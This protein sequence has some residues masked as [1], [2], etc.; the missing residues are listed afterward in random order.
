MRLF[1]IATVTH[2]PHDFT[3]AQPNFVDAM[4]LFRI[5]TVT[6][7]VDQEHAHVRQCKEGFPSPF[8]DQVWWRHD[9]ARKRSSSAVNQHASESNERLAR[10]T[11]RHD[12][13]VARKEPTLA[14]AHDC[15]GLSWIWNAHH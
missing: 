10:A 6:H 13:G 4:R 12:I 1:R 3:A 9:Q 14:H 5:A 2:E 7:V 11:L 8:L 15:Q